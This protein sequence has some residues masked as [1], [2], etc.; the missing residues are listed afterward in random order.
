M[1]LSISSFNGPCTEWFR[2]SQGSK[3]YT[4]Y[5]VK[6]IN[7]FDLLVVKFTWNVSTHWIIQR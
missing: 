3:E 2:I 5:R 6:N 7:F 4:K 1:L